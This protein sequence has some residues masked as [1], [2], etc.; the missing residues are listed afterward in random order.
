MK[1]AQISQCAIL[2]ALLAYGSLAR[3]YAV[4]PPLTLE[5]MVEQADL[6]FKG[7]VVSNKPA[8]D[9]AFSKIVGY[10]TQDTQFKIISVIKGDR[11]GDRLAFRHYYDNGKGFTPA[12]SSRNR[13]ALP[14]A[15]RISSSQKKLETRLCFSRSGRT[16]PASAIRDLSFAQMTNRRSRL[17]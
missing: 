7:T 1:I 16:A 17:Q 8:S 9:S 13:T 15:E 4:G 12:P 3:G 11:P 5:K 10:E 14:S 6:I 2:T